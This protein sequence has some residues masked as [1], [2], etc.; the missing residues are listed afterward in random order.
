MKN[1]GL[2]HSVYKVFSA[3]HLSLF[4]RLSPLRQCLSYS[5][6]HKGYHPLFFA[7]LFA[8]RRSP[9]G[10]EG[11]GLCSTPLSIVTFVFLPSFTIEYVISI[12]FSLFPVN[13][14][15]I[16]YLLLQTV[17]F[18]IFCFCFNYK[19]AFEVINRNIS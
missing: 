11:A 15:E 14:C 3:G 17:G 2:L 4:Q 19:A 10:V 7:S 12:S 6:S 16:Y 5:S 18:L 13:F 9:R 8:L 1:D